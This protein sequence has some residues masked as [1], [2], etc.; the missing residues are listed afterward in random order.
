MEQRIKEHL[1]QG[2]TH[3]DDEH[4]GLPHSLLTQW[5]TLAADLRTF[6]NHIDELG[7]SGILFFVALTSLNF[8]QFD[9]LS[10]VW[11]LPVANRKGGSP[12]QNRSEELQKT[13]F[14]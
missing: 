12:E 3:G 14:K 6:I 10:A 1:R 11:I 9:F 8:W 7:L 13:V 5:Y 2:T 4:S